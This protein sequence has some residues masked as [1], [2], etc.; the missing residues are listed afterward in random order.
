MGHLR[1]RERPVSYV[2]HLSCGPTRVGATDPC[3][4]AWWRRLSGRAVRLPRHRPASESRGGVPRGAARRYV[5]GPLDSAAAGDVCLTPPLAPFAEGT[6]NLI[7]SND[8]KLWA[9]GH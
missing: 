3:L 9:Q 4:A 8:L 7:R 2:A 1:S 6:R 5:A